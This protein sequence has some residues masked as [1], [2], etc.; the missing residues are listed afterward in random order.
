MDRGRECSEKQRE[1][2]AL[3]AHPAS[4]LTSS[5]LRHNED[6]HTPICSQTG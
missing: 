6:R 3:I 2:S 1:Q 4:I 5:I